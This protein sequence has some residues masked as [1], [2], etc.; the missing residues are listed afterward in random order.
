VKIQN[1]LQQEAEGRKLWVKGTLELINILDDARNRFSSDQ[2]FGTWLNDSGYGDRI[3]RHDRTALLNMARALQ[4]TRDVLKQTHRRSWEQIWIHEIQPRLPG[5]RQPP[6]DNKPEE[7]SADTRR[8]KRNR[9]KNGANRVQEPDGLRDNSEWFNNLVVR[10]NAVTDE[11]NKVMENYTPEQH[12]SLQTL[13]PTL[14]LEA[15]RK[16]TE[17]SA[18]FADWVK[19]PLEKAAD[20][21]IGEGRVKITPARRASASVQP[22]A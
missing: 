16:G 12:D 5:A 6:N 2:A 22:S 3:T 20:K 7:A 13:E 9:A 19:T 1:G 4:L 11:L 17:K 14:L 8:P 10:V 18:E 15:F 21:L